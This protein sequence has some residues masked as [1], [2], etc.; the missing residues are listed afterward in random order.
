MAQDV[1]E[2]CPADQ[3]GMHNIVCSQL[4]S[5]FSLWRCPQ[6]MSAARTRPALTTAMHTSLSAMA[7]NSS[8]SL[9]AL[10]HSDA[11]PR[12]RRTRSVFEQTGWSLFALQTLDM[13]ITNVV[14]VRSLGL[15]IFVHVLHQENPQSTMR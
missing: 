1:G 4:G 13:V 6:A 8:C 2:S 9:T 10:V 3:A 15:G 11:R 5:G 12:A 7:Q 14:L